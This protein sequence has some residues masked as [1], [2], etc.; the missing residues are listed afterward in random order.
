MVS[1]GGVCQTNG[2]CED[3]HA[4]CLNGICTCRTSYYNKHG[5]C[6][7]VC[8]H[9]RFEC[10]VVD[11]DGPDCIRNSLVCD[12][13]NDCH[14][15]SDERN[16]QTDAPL[17][18]YPH[19]FQK[20]FGSHFNSQFRHQDYGTMAPEK[21]I[22]PTAESS[23]DAAG[24]AREFH[25]P[26]P[27]ESSKDLDTA[28]KE[29]KKT[30]PDSKTESAISGDTLQKIQSKD[31][32]VQIV[33][34]TPKTNPVVVWPGSSSNE[35]IVIPQ[36]N[37]QEPEKLIPTSN[38]NQH[39]YQK[40]IPMDTFIPDS[41]ISSQ[42]K[43]GPSYFLANK[44]Q[45]PKPGPTQKTEVD[46]V[47]KPKLA[48][49]QRP[50]PV[51]DAHMISD[52]DSNLNEQSSEN[53]QPSLPF[54]GRK[55]PKNQLPLNQPGFEN[56][57][58]PPF[59]QQ[60]YPPDLTLADPD[61]R[62]G[63]LTPFNRNYSPYNRPQQQQ[64][65]PFNNQLNYQNRQP[66]PRNPFTPERYGKNFMYDYPDYE[67][68]Q[69]DS[70][71]RSSQDHPAYIPAP[72]LYNRFNS[73]SQDADKNLKPADTKIHPHHTDVHDKNIKKP[74]TPVKNVKEIDLETHSKESPIDTQQNISEKDIV[75]T[76]D[77]GTES[78]EDESNPDESKLDQDKSKTN[79]DESKQST[80]STESKEDQTK[81]TPKNTD[82]GSNEESKEE[83]DL[84]NEETE[85]L[86]VSKERLTV[87][88]SFQTAQGPIIALSLGL[89]FTFLLLVFIGCRLRN[90]KRRLRKGRVL[91]SN[92]ADY[93]INGMYL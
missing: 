64:F 76:S 39:P 90:M 40:E 62:Q 71:D 86:L 22:P 37:Q 27:T 33:P 36:N 79:P 61:E 8:G 44:P 26:Q 31:E 16:C 3:S 84:T 54:P 51:H 1:I 29:M 78:T 17:N 21:N 13:R 18:R 93:L 32:N 42:G 69:P 63:D 43:K 65:P 53:S 20:Q 88:S 5:T 4:F 30:N 58:Q 60:Q 14:D 19:W 35:D 77:E 81:D 12:G 89:A 72:G 66:P 9:S 68:Y 28:I 2:G 7:E 52:P 56:Y 25:Q 24:M 75:E 55:Y 82:T 92:E 48:K 91:H 80:D 83:T 15:G 74:S 49:T 10:K 34:A 41:M 47:P 23:V 70:E 59:R 45:V 57:Y 73:V 11:L 46:I 6:R 87:D 50:H 38:S 67:S 85:S